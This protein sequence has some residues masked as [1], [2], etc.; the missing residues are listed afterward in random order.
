MEVTDAATESFEAKENS[1]ADVDDVK[2]DPVE[3]VGKC[4]K[5]CLEC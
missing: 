3:N 2:A 4:S 1:A 5:L